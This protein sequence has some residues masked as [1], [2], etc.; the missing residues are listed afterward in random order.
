MNMNKTILSL[1]GGLVLSLAMI[2]CGGNGNN[3]ADGGGGSGGSGGGGGTPDM[4]FVC[5]KTPSSDTDFLNS[6][7]PTGVD[8][9]VISPTFPTLAPNGTLPALK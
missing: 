5:V 6:C 2:G 1:V 8:K 4:G 3:G 7:P 9:I